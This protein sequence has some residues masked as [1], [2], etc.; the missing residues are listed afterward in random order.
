MSNG[1]L[2]YLLAQASEAFKG[3][4]PAKK[5]DPSGFLK[6]LLKNTKPNIISTGVDD[7]SGVLRDVKVKYRQRAATGESTNTDDCSI[8]ARPVYLELTVPATTLFKKSIMLDD[9]IIARYQIE[10]Q[11]IVKFNSQGQPAFGTEPGMVMQELFEIIMEHAGALL[12][13]VNNSLLTAQASAFG[14][15]IDYLVSSV[16]SAAAQSINF[17]KS[18]ANNPL[19]DGMTAVLNQLMDNGINGKTATIIGSGLINAYMLQQA[20]VIGWNQFGISTPKLGETDYMY[21][22]FTGSAWGANQFGIFERD[23]IQ[24]VTVNKNRGSKVVDLGTHK[25]TTI[26][27]PIVDYTGDGTL[28]AFTFDMYLDYVPCPTTK[29]I[30]GNSTSVGRGWQLTLIANVATVGIPS[31][32]Y[33]TGDRL[34]GTNG[35]LRFTATN[36]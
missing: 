12:N 11:K 24:L 20:G 26:T 36:N 21:D 29:S 5:I 10:A 35:T 14:K 1:Y 28:E 2:P 6:Y 30:G 17:T 7:G 9:D 18:S 16:P 13:D 25:A 33:K 22:P 4:Y 23:A 19:T 27:L 31:D 8:D 3:A 15:N 32:A 34:A